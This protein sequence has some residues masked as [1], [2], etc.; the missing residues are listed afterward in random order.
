MTGRRSDGRMDA[1]GANGVG[2]IADQRAISDPLSLC[3]SVCLSPSFVLPFVLYT[4]SFSP[5]SPF[6]PT[7]TLCLFP[8]GF[9]LFL[10]LFLLIVTGWDT[11][12][13]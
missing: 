4:C 5:L 6:T 13:D 11:G 1:Q 8:P 12:R 2:A 3:L 9:F 10:F 7:F